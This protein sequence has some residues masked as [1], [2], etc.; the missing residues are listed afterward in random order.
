MIRQAFSKLL[1]EV[2]TRRDPVGFARSLG[3][4][5]GADAWLISTGIGTWGS[6]PFLIRI[7]DRVL[8]TAGV[9]FV[10]HDGAVWP[11][12]RQLPKIDRIAPIVIGDDCFIG[13][14]AIILPG[15]TIGDSSVVGAGAVVNR[16]VPPRTIV[17]GV[18]ARPVCT[19][20]EY[21]AKHQGNFIYGTR[22]VSPDERRRMM[23]AHVGWTDER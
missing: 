9:R 11:F 17:A 21:F 1:R 7:G 12:R 15:V 19:I 10:T 22:D 3:V 13:M 20:D 18:P 2:R 6:E 5:I 16:D 4:T 14:N 8:I 23:L